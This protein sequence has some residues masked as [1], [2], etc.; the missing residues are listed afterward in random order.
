MSGTP[1]RTLRGALLALALLAVAPVADAT[2]A[3][4]MPLPASPAAVSVATGLATARWGT[5]PC[6]GE[7]TISWAHLGRSVNAESRWSSP[8]G[9]DPSTYRNCAIAFSYDASWDWAKFCTV[10]EHELGHLAGHAH[11]DDDADVMSPFYFKPTPECARSGMPDGA[12]VAGAART[13]KAKSR[14]ASTRAHA[15]IARD[16]SARGRSAR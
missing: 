5:Q 12:A 11:V 3:S 8:A 7:V 4:S 2:A 16:R 10:A 1:L 14:A 9:G 6:G 15:R 13:T